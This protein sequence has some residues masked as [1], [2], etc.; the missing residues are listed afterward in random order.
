MNYD[1]IYTQLIYR[2]KNRQLEGY[3]E[4]HHIIPKC[5][6]GEDNSKNLVK[7]T[8]KEH[9]LVHKLLCE[10][11]PD[12]HKLLWALWMMAI[13]KKKWKHRDPYQITSRDYERI[14]LKVS[15]ARKGTK[16][17]ENVKKKIGE[18][19]SKPV[20]QF[21]MDGEYIQSFN[22]AMEAE[23]FI[24]NKPKAH[25]KELNNNINDCCRLKQK[26]AYGFI[27]KYN[28]FSLNLEQHKGSLN[29]KY[30]EKNKSN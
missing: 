8:A 3:S 21:S 19:N 26:S 17:S 25:W 2:A 10:I 15:E 22:S 24:N 12:N 6:G 9:F 5:M 1:K 18:K 13:G 29:K 4:T 20:Y 14:R 28:P 30:G 11:Y 23:R 27:W 16:L 7:L